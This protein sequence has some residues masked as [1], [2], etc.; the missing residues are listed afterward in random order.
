MHF[1]VH[2]EEKTEANKPALTTE[3]VKMKAQELR[4]VNNFY[5][6]SCSSTKNFIIDMILVTQIVYIK[7]Q[8]IVLFFH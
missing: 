7:L 5:F 8:Y 2:K 3:E 6:A 4:C 1:Q